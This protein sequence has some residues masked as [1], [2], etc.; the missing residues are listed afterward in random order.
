MTLDIQKVL[1]KFAMMAKLTLKDATDL[2]YICVES[3]DEISSMLKPNIDLEDEVNLRR[4]NTAAATLSLYKYVCCEM[5][6]DS[7]EQFTAGEVQIETVDRKISVDMARAL[8]KDAKNSISDLL[9]D[10]NFDFKEIS[11]L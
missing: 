9:I 4:L 2:I 3:I 5:S 8:W 7:M 10:R 1:E 11:N 6:G